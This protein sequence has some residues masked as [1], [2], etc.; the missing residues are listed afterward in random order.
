MANTKASFKTK[1][2][3]KRIKSRNAGRK[4]NYGPV[5]SDRLGPPA[6]EVPVERENEGR[7]K[8]CNKQYA[9]IMAKRF[10]RHMFHTLPPIDTETR[11]NPYLGFHVWWVILKINRIHT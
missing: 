10:V 7:A 2:F 4:I 11:R 1:V 9:N 6:K 5:L 3:P 8:S